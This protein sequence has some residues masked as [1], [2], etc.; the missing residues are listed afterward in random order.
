MVEEDRYK[1]YGDPQI[2]WGI[3][4]K[5]W[6][7]LFKCFGINQKSAVAA[8]VMLKLAREMIKSKQDNRDDIE[9]YAYILGKLE[10][11]NE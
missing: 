1:D 11:N 10:D 2:L 7:V 3:V 9:G 4:S 5:L 6:C 8:M